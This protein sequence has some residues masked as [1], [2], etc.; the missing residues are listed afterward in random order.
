MTQSTQILSTEFVDE[1]SES[2]Q[3]ALDSLF[4][5]E[6]GFNLIS[7]ATNGSHQNWSESLA[8]VEETIATWQSI[9][10]AMGEQVRTTQESLAE[11]DADLIRSL[12]MFA[13]ARKHLQ[14]EAA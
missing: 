5:H 7:T 2:I 14:S 6:S 1:I 10:D 11:L 8:Q 4:I 9:F 12:A 13:T 3:A